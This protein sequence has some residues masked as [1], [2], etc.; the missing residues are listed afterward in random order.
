[1][2]GLGTIHSLSLE[3]LVWIKCLVHA[4]VQGK[5]GMNR[6][7]STALLAGEIMMNCKNYLLG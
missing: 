1:M 3:C 2:P 5:E 4:E 7:A 6:L